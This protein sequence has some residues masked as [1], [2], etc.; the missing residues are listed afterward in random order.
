MRAAVVAALDR[1]TDDRGANPIRS[2][3]DLA[4]VREAM[5]N[6]EAGPV[7]VRVVLELC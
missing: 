5:K 7:D 6:V 1:P 2:V 4:G 3:R